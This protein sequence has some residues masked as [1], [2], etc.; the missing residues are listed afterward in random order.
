MNARHEQVA[1]FWNGLKDPI[2]HKHFTRTEAH[3]LYS[4]WC[5]SNGFESCPTQSFT[6]SSNTVF[7]VC[8]IPITKK[9]RGWR[10]F[11]SSIKW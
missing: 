9:T 7:G 5:D 10:L 2:E 11:P 1:T 4:Q 8:D 3:E 6:R